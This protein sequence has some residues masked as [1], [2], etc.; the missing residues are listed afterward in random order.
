[1]AP[2][3]STYLDIITRPRTGSSSSTQSQDLTKP[4]EED[5][6]VHTPVGNINKGNHS[7]TTTIIAVVVAIVG[8]IILLLAACCIIRCCY[9]K[10]S[11]NLA[12]KRGRVEGRG[13]QKVE[14]QEKLGDEDFSN[15]SYDTRDRLIRDQSPF[16]PGMQY[17]P[18]RGAGPSQEEGLMQKV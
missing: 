9:K 15:A 10:R 6:T 11:R 17:E 14:G 12:K 13:W 5:S 3:Y 4:L 16:T 2:Y 7:K 1:M 8:A 18:Y